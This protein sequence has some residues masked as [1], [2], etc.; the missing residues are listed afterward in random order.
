MNAFKTHLEGV[1]VDN[2]MDFRA[3]A[4]ISMCSWSGRKGNFALGVN[5]VGQFIVKANGEKF[6]FNNP[7]EAIDKYESF[8]SDL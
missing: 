2:L 7:A 1:T 4:F 6:T 5:G 8:F 3:E